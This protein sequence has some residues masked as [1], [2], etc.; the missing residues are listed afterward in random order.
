MYLIGVPV[1][2]IDAHLVLAGGVREREQNIGDFAQL[3]QLRTLH[4]GRY[5]SAGLWE[6]VHECLRP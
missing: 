4:L 2:P 6:R 3:L 1:G 5:H